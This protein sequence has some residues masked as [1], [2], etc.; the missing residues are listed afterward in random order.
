M[1]GLALSQ[2]TAVA[3]ASRLKMSVITAAWWFL[4]RDRRD[5][6]GVDIVGVGVVGV[7]GDVLAVMLDYLIDAQSAPKFINI[8]NRA[9]AAAASAP[10]LASASSARTES[11][12]CRALVFGSRISL[13]RIGGPSTISICA[14]SLFVARADA[15]ELCSLDEF[16]K[17]VQFPHRQPIFAGEV[18]PRLHLG[19]GQGAVGEPCE[20]FDAARRPR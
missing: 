19:F 13:P 2:R 7:N 15:A 12:T 16:N 8:S 14:R 4:G 5:Y 10:L 11:M 17:P 1:N 9:P 6:A 18:M 20:I 3:C